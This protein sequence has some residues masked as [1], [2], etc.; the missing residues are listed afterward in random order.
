MNSTS[1]AQQWP[2]L[3][4]LVLSKPQHITYMTGPDNHEQLAKVAVRITFLG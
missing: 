2:S 3:R 4:S 1:L